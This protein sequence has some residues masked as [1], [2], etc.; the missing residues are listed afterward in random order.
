MFC[1]QLNGKCRLKVKLLIVICISMGFPFLLG[2]AELVETKDGVV[3]Y[4]DTPKLP[5]CS[6][7][8][9]DPNRPVPAYVDPGRADLFIEP[10]SDAEVLFEGKNLS[11]WQPTVWKIEDGIL[12]AGHGDLVSRRFYGDCQLHLE[13][14]IPQGLN[15]VLDN[16][17]N[18][19]VFF[20]GL[21]EVQI[22]DSYPSHKKQ[23]YP[24]GQCA[25]IYGETPPLVNACRRE[26]QW[27]TFDIV[28]T[29]PLFKDGKLFKSASITML[30][31]GVLVHLN[32]IIHGP[33][34][35]RSILEYQPHAK[36]M[37]LKLQG[38][39]SPVR[40]RNIWIRPLSN[41]I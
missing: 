40:F 22:F 3:G 15:S 38:H 6:Y 36:K 29:A 4:S 37:P 14:M 30:H 25:A 35:W 11:A 2:A 33:V 23:I 17:G 28:F 19:G 26:G 9:H 39:N 18:S 12:E 27:Q 1:K 34:A 7:I 13:F 20:M 8:K 5:W 31:N 24:D 21:Y 41:I 32:T 10:P 16:R